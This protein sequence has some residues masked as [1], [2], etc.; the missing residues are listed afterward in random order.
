MTSTM[1]YASLV[2]TI[3][4]FALLLAN[5]KSVKSVISRVQ[6]EFVKK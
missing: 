5:V 6:Q 2:V 3:V 4:L 1:E